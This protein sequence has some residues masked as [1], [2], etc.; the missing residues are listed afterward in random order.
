MTVAE[1][2]WLVNS[3]QEYKK[4]FYEM[5]SYSTKNAMMSVMGGK[6]IRLFGDETQEKEHKMTKEDREAEI[7]YLKSRFK[8][9]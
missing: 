9:I 4:D 8:E 7:A 5:M 2:S 6:D 1:V 3:N